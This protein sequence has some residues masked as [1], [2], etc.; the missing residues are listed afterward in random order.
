MAKKWRDNG[1]GY[2]PICGTAC[3]GGHRCTEATLRG[4][5]SAHKREPDEEEPRR[6]SEAQRLNDGF[7]MMGDT[8]D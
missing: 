7:E 2:C 6:K 5:D 8:D 1:E 3:E 4:I